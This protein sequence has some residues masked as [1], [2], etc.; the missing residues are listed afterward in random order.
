MVHDTVQAFDEAVEILHLMCHVLV[1]LQRLMVLP[2][3]EKDEQVG[4][5]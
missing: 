4:K 5:R 2:R 1:V 3:C